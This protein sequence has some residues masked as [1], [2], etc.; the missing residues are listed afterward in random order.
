MSNLIIALIAA[1]IAIAGTF[2]FNL[3][4]DNPVEEVAEEIV[5]EETGIK[6][7]FTPSSPEK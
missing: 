2:I 4:P 7:D 6:M 1:A 3:P 5:Q